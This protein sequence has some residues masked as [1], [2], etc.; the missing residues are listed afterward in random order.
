MPVYEYRCENDHYSSTFASFADQPPNPRP[1]TQCDTVAHRYYGS[2]QFTPP[3]VEHFNPAVG[4]T[5]SSHKQF[6]EELKRASEAATISSGVETRFVETPISK[7]KPSEAQ[8]ARW[9]NDPTVVKQ[10]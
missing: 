1:C 3:V 9:A 8:L 5:I 4:K 7:L 6:R 2:I 10:S